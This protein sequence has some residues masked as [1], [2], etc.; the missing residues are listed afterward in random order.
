[1]FRI[2]T[3]LCLLF[4]MSGPCAADNLDSYLLQAV[5]DTRHAVVRESGGSVH[6]GVSGWLDNA[7]LRFQGADDHRNPFK[8]GYE[9]RVTPKYGTQRSA[10]Q[11]IY[12]LTTGQRVLNADLVLS[13]ALKSRYLMLIDF[14]EQRAKTSQ[15]REHVE[16]L[17]AEIKLNR[18]LAETTEFDPEKLQALL[19]ELSHAKATLH[20]AEQRLQAMRERIRADME[21]PDT[22]D[23][24]MNEDWPLSP[25][26]IDEVLTQYQ[27][28]LT[29]PGAYPQTRQAQMD[30]DI[31]TSRL[32]IVK[33][34][35][36]FNLD[37]LAV[38]YADNRDNNAV[39]LLLGFNLPIGGGRANLIDRHQDK[40]KARTRLMLT[41]DTVAALFT[42]RQALLK[43]SLSAWRTDYKAIQEINTLLTQP[44]RTQHMELVI[45]LKRQLLAL[46][47]SMSTT[48]MLLLRNFIVV[49]DAAG[50]LS[51]DPL[52][53]WIKDGQP[54]L[55]G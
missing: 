49:L 52:R 22:D 55:R 5:H 14:A 51:Q 9:L 27:E 30:L 42:E 13:S 53:N 41:R 12:E 50:F 1:M 43:W 24:L 48:H 4:T 31:A 7:Q 19:L 23:K 35:T 38:E 6:T 15:E 44:V 29:E 11:S 32:D 34:Q 20:M 46:N 36:S 2:T 25:P 47:R 33:A 37:L 18:S 21:S 8:K 39:G 10:E 28:A 45:G 26:H 40:G 54:E 3:T 17:N 16:L